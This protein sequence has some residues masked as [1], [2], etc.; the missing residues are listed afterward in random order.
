MA[1]GGLTMTKLEDFMNQYH[2]DYVRYLADY[3]ILYIEGNAAVPEIIINPKENFVDKANYISKAYNDDLELKN[4]P[5]IRIVN[6]RFCT[7]ADLFKT[8]PMFL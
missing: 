6:Y 8:T 5:K 1:V 7:R 2:S 3:L 4:N